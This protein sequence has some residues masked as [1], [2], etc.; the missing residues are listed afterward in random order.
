MSNSNTAEQVL[1]ELQSLG[2]PTPAN[3]AGM[4][5]FGIHFT[6]TY[7]VSVPALRKYAKK[8]KNNHALALS[9]WES[10]VHEAKLLATMIDDPAKV[11]E[12][13]MERWVKDFDSWDICDQCCGN[14]F[15]K[16]PFAYEMA[17]QWS[18]HDKEYIK[19]AGFVLMATLAV[20]DKKAED[21][22]FT[23]FFPSI[24][25]EA[26]DDRNFVKKAV[27]WALRQIGK[28]NNRLH[29][30]AITVAETIQS[31]GTPSARWIAADALREL[32][33]APVIARVNRN[34]KE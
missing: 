21:M 6:T 15:D 23:L 29:K 5:R 14:L 4:Q 33:S 30:Q 1:C 26:Y 8:L 24:E 31:Q 18:T 2:N 20:H 9:L 32:Q 22:K 28:R 11:T 34:G 3:I 19:R 12:G 13:Q 10:D 7:C 25:L 16:T 17:I 27:N